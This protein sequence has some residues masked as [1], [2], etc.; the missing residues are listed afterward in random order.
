MADN[1]SLVRAKRADRI[2]VLVW[3][4]TGIVLVHRQLV[5]A[6]FVWVLS[7]HREPRRDERGS[8]P[9]RPLRGGRRLRADRFR[10]VRCRWGVAHPIY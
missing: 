6:K 1:G 7:R 8:R 2:K 9:V 10:V 3:D 4:Q 5:G